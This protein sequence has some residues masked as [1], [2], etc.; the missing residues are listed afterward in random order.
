ML[1]PSKK[2][3]K[4]KNQENLPG[5]KQYRFNPHCVLETVQY[6]MPFQ[7]LTQRIQ[8]CKDQNNDLSSTLYFLTTH[9]SQ[10]SQFFA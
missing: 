7:V 9:F 8:V 10:E 1:G 4:S 6:L 2:F 3:I 5:L